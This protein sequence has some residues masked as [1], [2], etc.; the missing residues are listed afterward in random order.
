VCYHGQSRV[1]CPDCGLS[2]TLKKVE[3]IDLHGG[4]Y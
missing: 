1:T 3:K 4:G 2:G